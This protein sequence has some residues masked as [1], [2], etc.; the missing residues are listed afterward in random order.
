[1][2]QQ[3]RRLGVFAFILIGLTFAVAQAE[4]AEPTEDVQVLFI[5]NSFTFFHEMPKMVAELANAVDSLNDLGDEP[6]SHTEALH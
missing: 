5:G 1:M 6:P 2:N 4:A 3:T